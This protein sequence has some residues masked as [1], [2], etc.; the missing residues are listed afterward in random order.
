M[1]V[2]YS[3]KYEGDYL[4][5]SFKSDRDWVLQQVSK[6]FGY[7][8]FYPASL[9]INSGTEE[10]KV[11]YSYLKFN[12]SCVVRGNTIIQRSNLNPFV[13]PRMVIK[14]GNTGSKVEV[15]SMY[16]FMNRQ[17]GDAPT[18]SVNGTPSSYTLDRTSMNQNNID[19]QRMISSFTSTGKLR[20]DTTSTYDFEINKEIHP[21]LSISDLMKLLA[22]PYLLSLVFGHTL[23][24]GMIDNNLIS[25]TKIL[26]P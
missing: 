9:T 23:Y 25:S 22:F 10:F 19:P 17:V 5:Q 4:Y 13:R 24:K 11:K 7:I 21:D 16:D 12:M 14:E 2:G 18:V 20:L 3:R 26:T 6:E 8:P 15:I 1:K